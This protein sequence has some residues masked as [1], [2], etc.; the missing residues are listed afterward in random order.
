MQFTIVDAKTVTEHDGP[1]DLPALQIIRRP[2]TSATVRL[3]AGGDIGLSGRA[4]ATSNRLGTKALF[5]DIT[6]VIKSADIAFGNLESPLASEIAPGKMFA[7]P[8]TGARTL[9]DAGFNILHLA[10]NHVG[11]YGQAGLAA[12]L[13]AV[14][15]AGITAL[16]AGADLE[17]A[18]KLIRTDVR[19]LRV[20]WLGC[21]RTLIPQNGDGPRYWEFNERE[22]LAA[23]RQ[24]R[25]LVDVLI[26]S[27]HIGLMYMDYPRPEHKTMAERLMETG[28]DLI[29][30]HHAH[31]L[32]GVQV[33]PKRRV[34]CFNLGN[35]LYDCEEGLVRG[36]VMLQQQNEGGIFWFELDKKG[37]A[38]AAVFPT[39][40]DEDCRV[41]WATGE[42]G[43]AILRRLQSISRG[44]EGDFRFAFERQRA[45]RNAGPILAVLAVHIKHGNWRN[46]VDS[47]LRIRFEHVKMMI[48][49]LTGFCRTVP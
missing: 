35:L 37:V 29:L 24:A 38:L 44:L 17:A 5:A 2:P 41:H 30:M 8:V 18:K 33:T 7:A 46:I 48:R 16:G 27:M 43:Y 32:Q 42:R 31:V 1:R 9:H 12:T 39:W 21:G 22:L 19:R 49:W 26:V 25:P 23:I 14:Q 36:T 20:G 6:D 3:C 45:E 11:E 13:E 10:N 47:L 40:I 15:S 28:A 4:A 34:C